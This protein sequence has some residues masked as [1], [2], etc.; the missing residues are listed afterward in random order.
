MLSI[1]GR[2]L[3][4]T[5][6]PERLAGEVEVVRTGERHRFRDA[7]ELLELLSRLRVDDPDQR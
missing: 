1:V 7:D 6:S 5:T 4:R 2:L 3:D